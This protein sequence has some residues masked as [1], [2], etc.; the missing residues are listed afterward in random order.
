MPRALS[1]REAQ[2]WHAGVQLGFRVIPIPLHMKSH[3]SVGLGIASPV[4]LVEAAPEKGFSAIT[5]TDLE[6]LTGQ[7][8]FHAAWRGD[9]ERV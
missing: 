1:R 2:P 7:P 6:T 8:R 4:R 3:Y 9:S 5:L